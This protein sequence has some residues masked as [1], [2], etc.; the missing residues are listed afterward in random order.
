MFA[1]LD[2]MLPTLCD[3]VAKTLV[4]QN[5]SIVGLRADRLVEEKTFKISTSTKLGLL[6]VI[7]RIY[8]FWLRVSHRRRPV[9]CP[10]S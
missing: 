2:V 9:P 10:K 6:W 7:F 3:P 5:G 8:R 1:Q 4:Q